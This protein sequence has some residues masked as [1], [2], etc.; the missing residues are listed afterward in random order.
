MAPSVEWHTHLQHNFSEHFFDK[1]SDRIIPSK[2]A[3]C[4]AKIIFGQKFKCQN[5]FKSALTIF[6][7]GEISFLSD[8]NWKYT[9]KRA[10][11]IEFPS[12][13]CTQ[14]WK[15][16]NISSVHSQYPSVMRIWWIWAKMGFDPQPSI[17][18]SSRMTMSPF[19]TVSNIWKT[20]FGT[21]GNILHL[22]WLSISYNQIWVGSQAALRHLLNIIVIQ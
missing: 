7:F 1:L 9:Q 13:T 11:K 3:H 20:N 17:T 22:L 6:R 18:P 12:K 15:L 5:P 19:F 2:Y 16:V 10:M 21:P 8:W 4:T 14:I